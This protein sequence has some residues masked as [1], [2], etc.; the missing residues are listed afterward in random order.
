M[1]VS[2]R[3]FSPV[4][5][6]TRRRASE[7]RERCRRHRLARKMSARDDMKALAI[8]AEATEVKFATADAAVDFAMSAR[9][10]E[11][12]QATS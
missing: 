1:N 2:R 10:E 12:A 7:C 9:N 5:S 3:N 6:E 8:G 4:S 11:E